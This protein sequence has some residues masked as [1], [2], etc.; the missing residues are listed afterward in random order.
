[1]KNICD[2]NLIFSYQK[3]SFNYYFFSHQTFSVDIEC[4][5]GGIRMFCI[6]QYDGESQSL[7]AGVNFFDRCSCSLETFL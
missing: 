2:K 3:F 7:K 6:I 1:M 5:L 4:I